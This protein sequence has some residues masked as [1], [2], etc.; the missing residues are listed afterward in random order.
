MVIA[1]SGAWV[2]RL[3]W[4]CRSA[5][6]PMARPSL[7]AS[8]WTG[9]VMAVAKLRL[10]GHA[11]QQFRLVDDRDAERPGLFHLGAGVHTS[12]HGG[13]LFRD[14]VGHVPSRLLDA[15]GR[16]G[17]REGRERSRDHVGLTCEAAPSGARAARG[18]RH[19]L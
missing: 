11:A 13:R 19:G 1:W 6:R 10:F 17:A 15:L 3:V 7:P 14:A 2:R 8:R 5:P 12:D 16:L 18:G 9:A 4:S